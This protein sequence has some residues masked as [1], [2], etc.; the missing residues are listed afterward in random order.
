MGRGPECGRLSERPISVRAARLLSDE[1]ASAHR[2]P[3][4]GLCPRDRIGAVP[5]L[6]QLDPFSATL[7]DA[8]FDVYAYSL[9]LVSARMMIDSSCRLTIDTPI[10]RTPYAENL[11]FYFNSDGNAATGDPA[12]DGADRYVF[13][14]FD[15][16]AFIRTWDPAADG[17]AGHAP[18]EGSW[19]QNA[20]IANW[21]AKLED[22]GLVPGTT[23]TLRVIADSLGD[24]L[25]QMPPFG[26]PPYAFPVDFAVP[27]VPGPPAPPL[28][29]TWPP[30]PARPS[31]RRSRTSRARPVSA[32]V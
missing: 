20:R 28:R 2:L 5:G 9:D 30:S 16:T 21:R 29:R 3:G 24:S 4:A 22:L 32:S 12:M 27:R 6:R 10:E 25:D 26:S 18:V 15:G 7:D 8:R 19:L 31:P 13:F 11:Q 14:T 17:Y 1:E 23:A